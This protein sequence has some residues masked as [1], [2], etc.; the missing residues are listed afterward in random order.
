MKY[1]IVFLIFYAAT[2]SAT[3]FTWVDFR[4]TKHFTNRVQDIPERYRSK[5]K[6]LYPEPSDTRSALSSSQEPP[7]TAEATS[8]QPALPQPSATVS[9]PPNTNPV[10]TSTPT[11]SKRRVRRASQ[12]EE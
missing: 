10:S 4:G 7:K 2:A 3:V 1:V 6:P 9:M 11:Q 12:V 5:A 8:V